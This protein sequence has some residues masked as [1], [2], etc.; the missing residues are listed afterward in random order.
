MKR[1]VCLLIA[2]LSVSLL[3]GGCINRN[4][5]YTVAYLCSDTLNCD[6][7]TGLETGCHDEVFAIADFRYLYRS[8]DNFVAVVYH[9]CE[10]DIL[11]FV[12]GTL[13]YYDYMLEIIGNKNLSGGTAAKH[14]ALVVEEGTYGCR[15]C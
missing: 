13:R 9:V 1:I 4:N 7:L 2:A 5:D 10:T 3:L 11:K 15:T 8:G 6:A 12:G 14:P